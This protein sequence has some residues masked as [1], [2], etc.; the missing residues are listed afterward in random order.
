ML[1]VSRPNDP[2]LPKPRGDIKRKRGPKR[3]PGFEAAL[4]KQTHRLGGLVPERFDVQHWSCP[5][6][7]VIYDSH[8]LA[9]DCCGIGANQVLVCCTCKNKTGRLYRVGDCVCPPRFQC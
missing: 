8:N 9:R 2:S 7:G 5:K 3:D 6:C 1:E 4:L